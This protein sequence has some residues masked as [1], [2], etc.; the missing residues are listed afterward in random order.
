LQTPPN[1]SPQMQEAV[2]E[3][4]SYLGI[5]SIPLK[6]SIIDPHAQIL[7]NL[8]RTVCNVATTLNHNLTET[9]IATEAIDHKF[10]EAQKKSC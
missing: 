5:T 6:D 8:T 4:N 9:V 7:T 3:T 2:N 10:E 1:L